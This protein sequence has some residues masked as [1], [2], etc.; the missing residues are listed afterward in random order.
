MNKTLIVD[1]DGVLHWYREGWKDGSIYDEP[2]PGARQ[3]M[4]ELI[5]I[6]YKIVIFST[7]AFDRTVKGVFEPS[8]KG[9]MI[10][11]LNRYQI[12]CHDIWQEHGKPMGHAYLDDR[13]IQFRGNWR[14]SI[15][16][17]QTFKAWS[18]QY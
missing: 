17:I 2:V 5:E 6:G 9:E 18:T 4:E 10:D 7:R 3:A 15:Q 1:F 16:S 12:P 11:W 14:E 13:A 8:Q